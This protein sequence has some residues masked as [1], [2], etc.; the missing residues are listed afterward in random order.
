MKWSDFFSYDAA[1]GRLL[2]AIKKPGRMSGIGFEAGSVK[3][4]GRYRSVVVNHKRYYT[5]RIVWEMAFGPIPDG[6]CI[7]HLDGNG[8][9]NR[10]ANL[11]ITTLS[12]NQRNR[13]QQRTNKIGIAGVQRHN[14]HAGGY[15]VQCA[16]KYVG[17]AHDFFEACC[18]RKSAEVRHGYINRKEIK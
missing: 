12:G 13:R 1:T 3:H 9:N 18:L 8:L 11:R 17:H 15:S 10:L 2:W 14:R 7:D 6:M 16:G 5:H 4:D